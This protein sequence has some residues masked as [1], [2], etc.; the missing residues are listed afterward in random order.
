MGVISATIDMMEQEEKKRNIS[1]W[2][3]K[4]VVQRKHRREGLVLL[5]FGRRKKT[6]E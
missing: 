6:H 5:L 1:A 2:R 4:I 3:N